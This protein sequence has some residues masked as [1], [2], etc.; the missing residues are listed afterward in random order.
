[1]HAGWINVVSGNAEVD[2]ELIE[3]LM[4]WKD[5]CDAGSVTFLIF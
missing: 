5:L 2:N 3:P 4:L 1:M